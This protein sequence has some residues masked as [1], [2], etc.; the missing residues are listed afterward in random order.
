MKVSISKVRTDGGF[1]YRIEAKDHATGSPEVCN[2][3]SGIMYGIVGYMMNRDDIEKSY[4]L[5]KDQKSPEAMAECWVHG[6]DEGIDAIW[7]FFV[8]TILQI[9]QSYPR[10]IDV[11]VY[12][13]ELPADKGVKL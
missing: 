12:M 6:T 3:I 5:E 10:Y 7:H 1:T 13:D 11:S 9:E 4:K 2:A 8:I